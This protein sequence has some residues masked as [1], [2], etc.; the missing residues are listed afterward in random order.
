[1]RFICVILLISTLAL[2]FHT[3]AADVDQDTDLSKPQQ[4][5]DDTS[6]FRGVE[7][8]IDEDS[9][10][11][12]YRILKSLQDVRDDEI[13]EDQDFN[14]DSDD[15]ED[16][17]QEEDS[18][19]LFDEDDDEDQDEDDDDFSADLPEFKNEETADFFEHLPQ[20][21]VDNGDNKL[22]IV[23]DNIEVEDVDEEMDELVPKPDSGE[24]DDEDE[25]EEQ[26]DPDQRNENSTPTPV[27]P[28]II[29][30]NIPWN[31]PEPVMKADEN[32]NFYQDINYKES[33]KLKQNSSS[34][35]TSNFQ[36]WHLFFIL[37]VLAIVYNSITK[38][39]PHNFI[40]LPLSSSSS[41][42]SWGNKD[43]K[44][45]LPVSIKITQQ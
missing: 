2:L 21:P 4:N 38:R 6:L 18:D 20:Q 31:R 36:F 37:M 3:A 17:E 33:E 15:E 45:Y 30:E 12:A 16:E 10:D 14:P 19:L 41:S 34:N 44:D 23:E 5:D 8:A 29:N 28:P 35:N 43:E 7:N 24:E 1:M 13:D 27:L 11:D 32:A 40:E 42:L 26:D 9:E 25:E 39:K 22:S